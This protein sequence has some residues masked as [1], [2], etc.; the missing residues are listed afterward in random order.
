MRALVRIFIRTYQVVVSPALSFLGGPHSGCR[1]APTCSEYFLQAVEVHGL[2]RGGFLGAKRLLRCHPWGG[3]G[4]DPVPLADSVV[5]NG[6]C[7]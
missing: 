3:S 2:L 5:G 6:V 7:D 1:F 4:F